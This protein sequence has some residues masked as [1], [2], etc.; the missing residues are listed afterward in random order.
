MPALI[1]LALLFTFAASAFR[2]V[3]KQAFYKVLEA[4]DESR[5]DEMVAELEKESSSAT[6]KAYMGALIMKKAG[7]VKGASAK[8]K[9]FKKGAQ[10]LEDEIKNNPGN[11]EYRFLRLTIQEHAPGILKYN[12]QLE[13]DKAA[14]VKGYSGLEPALKTIIRD[15][16]RDSR[17]LKKE[18]LK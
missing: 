13:E 7:F 1:C 3:D 18:D 11:T 17:V 5:I 10:L 9:T 16:A 8:V 2:P 15:Y 6:V 12:K 14:V 4:G